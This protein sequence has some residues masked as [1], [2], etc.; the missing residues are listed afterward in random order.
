MVILIALLEDFKSLPAMLPT[1]KP[2]RPGLVKPGTRPRGL[3]RGLV[4]GEPDWLGHV[5]ALKPDIAS[6]KPISASTPKS[7][8]DSVVLISEILSSQLDAYSIG[9]LSQ[10][11]DA[12]QANRPEDSSA[13]IVRLVGS[14]AYLGHIHISH[15]K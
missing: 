8:S 3:L 6:T 7:D 14:T 13:C 4:C 1:C 12:Y 2:K 10:Q 15:W 11:W 9:P 5:F